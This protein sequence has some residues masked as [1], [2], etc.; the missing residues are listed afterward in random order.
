ERKRGDGREIGCTPTTRASSGRMEAAFETL[1]RS[2]R[3]RRQK[4]RPATTRG[5]YRQGRDERC[6]F[7]FLPCLEIVDHPLELF[8]FGGTQLAAVCQVG[9]ERRQRSAK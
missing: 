2:R 5:E 9:N 6:S 8:K 7:R 1:G 3:R 4:V